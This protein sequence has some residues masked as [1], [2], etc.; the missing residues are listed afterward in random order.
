MASSIFN[1]LQWN[2]LANGLAQPAEFWKVA[3]D[4]L[5]WE[6]RR[7]RIV[8]TVRS[9][10]AEICC[11]QELNHYGDFLSTISQLI[12]SIFFFSLKMTFLNLQWEVW[13]I[14]EFSIQ[15]ENHHQWLALKPIEIFSPHSSSLSS[16]PVSTIYMLGIWMSTRWLCFFL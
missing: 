3:E 5:S 11:F 10:K 13:V 1:I 2:I 7:E 14:R 4:I 6:S 15:N 12:C 8:G 16:F 9:S